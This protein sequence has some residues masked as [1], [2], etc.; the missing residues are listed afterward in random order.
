MNIVTFVDLRKELVRFEL[1][2]PKSLAI[3]QAIIEPVEINDNDDDDVSNKKSKKT[4]Q[5]LWNDMKHIRSGCCL[6]YGSVIGLTVQDPRLKFPQK[7]RPL[8]EEESTGSTQSVLD[9]SLNWPKEA[10][11]SDI[12]DEE[13]RKGCF[14]SKPTETQ[15]SQRRGNVSL[16]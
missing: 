11:V 4:N 9:L 6:P 14:L 2:G 16:F 7:A 12:W 5:Q 10:S 15:L 1:T 13:I 3:L 8:Y